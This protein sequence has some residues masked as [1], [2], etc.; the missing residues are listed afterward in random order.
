MARRV[1]QQKRPTQMLDDDDTT[2]AVDVRKK[3]KTVAVC[4]S[5][6]GKVSCLSILTSQFNT[7]Y[8]GMDPT[9]QADQ[10]A[11]RSSRSNIGKG[12]QKA[13]LENIERVQT[14][15]KVSKLSIATSNE[16]LNP[17]AP[18]PRDNATSRTSKGFHNDAVCDRQLSLTRS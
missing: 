14:Q 17:M 4:L 9:S 16:P 15:T 1:R 18:M 2:L 8:A 11:R 3:I 6:D 7:P 12:G 5:G 13:Q 10:M